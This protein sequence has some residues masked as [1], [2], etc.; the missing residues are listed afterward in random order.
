MRIRL[1][2]IDELLHDESVVRR[3][4]TMLN[5][6]I[7]KRA[8]D[9][10]LEQMMDSLR[11]RFRI[12]G[13]LIKQPSFSIQ[14]SSS[15][16]ARLKILAHLN[17]VERRLPQDGKFQFNHQGQVIDMRISTFPALHGEK[18]VVRILDRSMQAID[19]NDI[20][21]DAKMLDQFK[22]LMMRHSGFF[23]V[24][25]PTGSGK[26][27]TLYAALSFLNSSEKNIVTLED[28]VEYSLEGVTQ[29]QIHPAAGF[30]FE[31][32]IRS[33]VRQDP[34]IIMIGEIRDKVTAKI[35]I[36]AAL[37]GHLVLSTLH[38]GNAPNA[39]MRLI[40]MEI[41]P[42]LIN[43]ALSG[44]LAQRLARTLCNSC[45]QVHVP[46]EEESIMLEKLGI[47]GQLMYTASGCDQCHNLGYKGRTGIFELL[48]VTPDL[49]VL[50]AQKAHFDQIYQQACNDGMKPLIQDGIAKLVQ[51]IISLDE[52]VRVLL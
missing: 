6:A 23:L 48:E 46:T 13:I 36:E 50:I 16:V 33:V 15:I 10:H 39:I 28:P 43:A 14:L 24:T 52:L 32:G 29:A 26:T 51:G 42:F 7:H 2:N 9:I 35:A 4:E 31:Q 1:N 21:F 3:V 45:K 47:A 37:T 49:R 11:I 27:T 12:D 5:D 20:G 34:D 22:Q 38:T 18:I 44:V 30:T 25:G 19:M 17:S 8:S 41:E 40:D